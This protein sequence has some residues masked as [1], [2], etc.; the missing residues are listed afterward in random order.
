MRTTKKHKAKKTNLFFYVSVCLLLILCVF[1]SM[2]CVFLLILLFWAQITGEQTANGLSLPVLS[3]S[4]CLTIP[5]SYTY[6]NIDRTLRIL[7]ISYA[8]NLLLLK[9]C[10]LKHTSKA[11]IMQ[12]HAAENWNNNQTYKLNCDPTRKRQRKLKRCS[13]SFY[14]F[15]ENEVRWK[16]R[17]A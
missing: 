2:L 16:T 1:I 8:S 7:I 17:K 15:E 6:T 4:R 3:S 10:K 14:I 9:K 11:D 13:T 5:N 12:P